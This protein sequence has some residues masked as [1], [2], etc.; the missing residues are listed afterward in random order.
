[1]VVDE[2]SAFDDVD[3]ENDAELKK[4][5]ASL[6]TGPQLLRMKSEV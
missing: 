1:M 6:E 2:Q 4:T 3:G 5:M